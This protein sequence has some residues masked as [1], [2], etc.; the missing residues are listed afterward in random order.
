MARAAVIRGSLALNTASGAPPD[1]SFTFVATS[2]VLAAGTYTVTLV[3]GASGIKDTS[4]V[5]LDGTD[6]GIPGNNYVT[7]FTVASTPSVVL[8]IPDF[9]RGPNSAA[10]ILLPNN[11]GSGI[12]ITLTGAANLTAC[13][14]QPDLQ[15][16][17]A[18]H[19]RHAQWPLRHLHLAVQHR[20]RG[21]LR[22]SAAA[23]L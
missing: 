17:T 14:L 16:R 21:Q 13:D 18:Q 5:E 9:A 11:T 7:T 20:R 1:T 12:P 8:S 22:L 10:N 3:S 2:G 19:Q 15:P 6:S 23:H 4:G